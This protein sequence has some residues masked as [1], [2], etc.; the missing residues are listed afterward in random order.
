MCCWLWRSLTGSLVWQRFLMISHSKTG[1]SF[2]Y[3]RAHPPVSWLRFLISQGATA[4]G[5]WSGS[6]K[7][8]LSAIASPGKDNQGC[9]KPLTIKP[10]EHGF[11]VLFPWAKCLPMSTL[12]LLHR[13]SQRPWRFG[14]GHLHAKMCFNNQTLI[15]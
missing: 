7:G 11:D 10:T 5:T 13:G 1:P 8:A 2:L 6:P 3:G 15:S 9:S 12:G 4:N 14:A